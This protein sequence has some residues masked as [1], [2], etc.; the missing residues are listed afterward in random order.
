MDSSPPKKLL[1]MQTE[2]LMQ[3]VKIAS[4][5]R[6]IGCFRRKINIGNIADT[7]FEI[8]IKD[9]QR[10]QNRLGKLGLLIL[11]M[12]GERRMATKTTIEVRPPERKNLGMGW[13]KA[14]TAPTADVNRN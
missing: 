11:P 8:Q 4:K 5:T 7:P 3:A 13:T 14:P 1:R 10:N 2:Q 6:L 9:P 12:K